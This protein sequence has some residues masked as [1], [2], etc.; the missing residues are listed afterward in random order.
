MFLFDP[1]SFSFDIDFVFDK[2]Y[3]LIFQILVVSVL[4]LANSSANEW[5]HL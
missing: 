3:I 1:L 4:Y 2:A 5:F